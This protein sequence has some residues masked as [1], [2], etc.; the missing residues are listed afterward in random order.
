MYFVEPNISFNKNET[1]SEMQNPKH[2]FG[3][4]ESLCFSLYRT[5]KLKAKLCWVGARERKKR[6]FFVPFTL[7][8]GV[9]LKNLYFISMYS[10]LNALKYTFT[11]QRT[12][13]HALFYLFLKLWKAFS[14]S[15]NIYIC[16]QNWNKN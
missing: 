9:F 8:G 14:G 1:E 13:L 10:V 4:R 7:F 3:E 5:C 6:E 12:L 16:K 15:L 11:Y 2:R